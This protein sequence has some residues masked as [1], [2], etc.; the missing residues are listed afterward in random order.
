MSATVPEQLMSSVRRST[1]VVPQCHCCGFPLCLKPFGPCAWNVG[2]A[3]LD[4]TVSGSW[5]GIGGE[6]PRLGG[7]YGDS[8]G[9]RTLWTPPVASRERDAGNEVYGVRSSPSCSSVAPVLDGQLLESSKSATAAGRQREAQGWYIFAFPHLGQKV[10]TR[11][12]NFRRRPTRGSRRQSCWGICRSARFGACSLGRFRLP[13]AETSGREAF[14]LWRRRSAW[15]RPTRRLVAVEEQ[16][17]LISEKSLNGAKQS[18]QT[19]PHLPVGRQEIGQEELFVVVAT[20]PARWEL[21]FIGPRPALL[22]RRAMGECLAHGTRLRKALAGGEGPYGVQRY[23]SWRRGS[24]RR[25]Q[26]RTGGRLP[27]EVAWSD[28][29]LPAS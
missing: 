11:S 10:S 27:S 29:I 26:K 21:R 19:E 15:R 14:R 25:R 9:A 18:M 22:G 3:P 28:L 6:V 16:Q 20:S 17:A 5:R 2:L 8:R 24:L 7:G 1:T 13:A 4:G 23:R 12:R